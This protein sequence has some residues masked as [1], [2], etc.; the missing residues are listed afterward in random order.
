VSEEFKVVIEGVQLPAEQRES[1]TRSIQRAVL[2]HLG[3][4]DLAGDEKA[5]FIVHG[6][7]QGIWAVPRPLDSLQSV[8]PRSL[9]DERE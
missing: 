5:A 7:T 9:L 4:L 3:D 2:S 6:H 1:I 8:V